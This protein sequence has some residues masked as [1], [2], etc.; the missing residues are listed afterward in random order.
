MPRTRSILLVKVIDPDEGEGDN[1]SAS[2]ETGAGPTMLNAV[3]LGT[4]PQITRTLG[5]FN[6]APDGDPLTQGIL[7]GPGLTVQLPMTGDRDP[8]IQVMV[9]LDEEDMAWPVVLRL[10]RKLEWKI[11]D[12]GTGKIFR[13]G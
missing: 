13:V 5:E 2:P 6:I 3:P 12:P 1:T 4:M 10:C 8:V 7:F 9:T 11:M